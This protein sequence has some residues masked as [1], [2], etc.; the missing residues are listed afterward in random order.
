MSHIYS[1]LLE[2]LITNM[3]DSL[4]PIHKNGTETISWILSRLRHSDFL[5]SDRILIPLVFFPYTFGK[6]QQI[7]SGAA[8]GHGNLSA[9]KY[10]FPAEGIQSFPYRIVSVE[11]DLSVRRIDDDQDLL[12]VITAQVG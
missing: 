11:A 12:P 6:L 3:F 7:K 5:L 1:F 8:P 4:K 10:S 9:C 2:K